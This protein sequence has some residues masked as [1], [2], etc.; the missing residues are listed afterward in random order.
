MKDL[1]T[2]LSGV[3]AASCS[4][5]AL[6]AVAPYQLGEVATFIPPEH[7]A[8]V[9]MVGMLAAWL[10]RCI[11]SVVAKDA[12]TS[13]AKNAARTLSILVFLTVCVGLVSCVAGDRFYVPGKII[14]SKGT[15]VSVPILVASLN[16]DATGNVSYSGF[17]H[18]YSVTMPEGW[19]GQ[20]ST[21]T[22]YDRE[23]KVV[24]TA[25]QPVIGGLSTSSVVKAS[26]EAGS[27]LAE[28]IGSAGVKAGVGAAAS[29]VLGP[30]GAAIK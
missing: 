3:L 20:F 17:G 10:L 2:T 15:T 22:I 18:S 25:T 24:S 1:K 7:K 5:L 11:N 4:L 16:R 21:A 23:G 13:E 6:L 26:G 29:T 27:K 12:P 9:F 8:K 14:T 28:S 30:I 19:T